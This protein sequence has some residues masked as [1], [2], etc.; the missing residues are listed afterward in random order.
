MFL[1][2]ELIGEFKGKNTAYRVLPD[3]KIETMG[4]GMGKFMGVDAFVMSTA[5]GTIANGVFVGEVNSMITTKDGESAMMK[6]YAVGY[7]SGNGGLTRGAS[8]PMTQAP[9]LIRLNKTVC[10]TEFE[11]DMAD[12]WTGKIWEWK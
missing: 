5:V 9:K 2:S 6:G 12:S 10:L 3:G 7:P 11:T 4:Q 1:E 8:V